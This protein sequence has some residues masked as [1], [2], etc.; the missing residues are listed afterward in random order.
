MTSALDSLPPKRRAFVEAYCGE[1]A[2]NGAEAARIAGYKS[3]RTQASRLLTFDNVARAIAEHAQ[4]ATRAAI[5]TAEERQEWLSDVVRG[6]VDDR[7]GPASLRDRMKALELLCRMR[8]DFID[9]TEVAQ[10]GVSTVVHL[11]KEQAAALAAEGD[12]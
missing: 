6:L 10:I 3:P 9:R 11:T 8:G 5:A 2:G 1:A 7:D 12:D 4:K